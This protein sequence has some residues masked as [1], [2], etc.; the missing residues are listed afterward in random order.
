MYTH[1]Q[2]H[3]H[4]RSHALAACEETVGVH[5]LLLYQGTLIKRHIVDTQVD[6]QSAHS[7]GKLLVRLLFWSSILNI[8]GHFMTSVEILE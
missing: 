6:G 4:M 7:F 8:C 1:V 3:S 2:S 5:E